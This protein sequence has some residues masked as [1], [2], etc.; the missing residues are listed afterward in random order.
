M[1]IRWS[2]RRGTVTAIAAALAALA[3]S[4]GMATAA[5]APKPAKVGEPPT[6]PLSRPADGEQTSPAL[7]IGSGRAYDGWLQIDAYRWNPPAEVGKGGSTFACSWAESETVRRPFYGSCDDVSESG[8]PITL[9]GLTSVLTP[10]AGHT[11]MIDG[12]LGPG[13]ARVIVSV[14][15]P[16][17]AG[18]D[19]KVHAVIAWVRGKLLR[20][21]GLPRP[22]GRFAAKVP[23][24]VNSEH[25]VVT[26]YDAHGK[27]LG[28]DTGRIPPLR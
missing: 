15:R 1:S 18:G 3:L 4:A 13:V 22:F 7:V 21:L 6:R 9:S 25:V 23:G 12:S 10:P 19:V 2:G 20:A 11:T 14:K 16:R 26:A 8:E 17:S 27:R 24:M 5:D 28:A